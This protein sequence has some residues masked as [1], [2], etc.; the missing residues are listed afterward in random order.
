MRLTNNTPRTTSTLCLVLFD[1][2]LRSESAFPLL[3]WESIV[4]WWS[5]WSN[6]QV[7]DRRRVWGIPALVVV[8]LWNVCRQL[9]F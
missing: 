4:C 9:E 3:L 1:P 7:H 5:N 6:R 8:W 2:A